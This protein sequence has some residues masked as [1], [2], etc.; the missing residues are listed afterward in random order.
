MGSALGSGRARA[1]QTRARGED[2]GF[3]SYN[4]TQHRELS[5]GSALPLT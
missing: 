2:D 3:A 1:T 4:P 5:L